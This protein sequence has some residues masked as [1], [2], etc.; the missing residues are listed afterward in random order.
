ML[1]E[2]CCG[3]TETS[4]SC[5]LPGGRRSKVHHEGADIQQPI[6]SV[7][8]LA[9][10]RYPV[11]LKTAGGRVVFP[12]ELGWLPMHKRGNKVWLTADISG[13]DVDTNRFGQHI[14]PVEAGSGSLGG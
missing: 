10:L 7:G 1:A 2:K 6:L 9:D 8:L 3:T 11:N 12:G 4:V 13:S 5:D 14:M